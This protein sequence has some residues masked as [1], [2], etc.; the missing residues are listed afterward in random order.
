[1]TED[2]IRCVCCE[3]LIETLFADETRPQSG[4]YRNAVVDTLTAGYGSKFDMD[5]LLLAVCDECMERAIQKG[6]VRK[7]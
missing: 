1:M 5:R 6:L 2:E 7:V 3:K 4:A